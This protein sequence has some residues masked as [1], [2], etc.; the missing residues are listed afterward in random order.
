[1]ELKR[2][3]KYSLFSSIH[4]HTDAHCFV[5]VLEGS[6]LETRFAWPKGVDQQQPKEEQEEEQPMIETGSEL[7]DL[8]GVTYISGKAGKKRIYRGKSLLLFGD[9]LDIRPYFGFAESF[10]I[11]Q[12]SPSIYKFAI[13][14][15]N[16]PPSDGESLPFGPGNHPASLHSPIQPLPSV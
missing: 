12:Y 6:L 10:Q 1:M 4:D 15:S 5:K 13:S 3:L 9:Y 16:W 14:R 7:Y 2:I 11:R 8:N